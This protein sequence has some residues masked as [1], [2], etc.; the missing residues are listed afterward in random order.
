MFIKTDKIWTRLF[1]HISLI[2]IIF[3]FVI[4]L[5]NGA[6]MERFFVLY[7]ENILAKCA[8][9]I[10]N[11]DITDTETA[12]EKLYDIESDNNVN[13]NIYSDD[14]LVYSTLNQSSFGRPGMN[15]FNLLF[16]KEE[17]MKIL[18][19]KRRDN[20]TVM[21]TESV[22]GTQYIFYRRAA[23]NKQ[24][25]IMI[26][27]S[28]IQQSADVAGGFI[29]IL[30]V[31][32]LAF[33]LIGCIIFSKRFAQ[34]ITEIKDIAV[35]MSKLDFS[36]TLQV[37]G[38]DEISQ[39][40]QSINELSDSLDS[41]LNELKEKNEKLQDEIELERKL[42]VMRKD[43]VANVSHELKTPIAIIQGYA[44]GLRNGGFDKEKS[45]KYCDIIKEESERMN[46]LVL[47]LLELSKLEGGLKLNK[48]RFD[49]LSLIAR[50]ADKN[51]VIMSKKGIVPEIIVPDELYVFADELYIEQALQNYLSNAISHVDEK[52]I[53]RITCEDSGTGVRIGVYNSGSGVSPEDMESIWQ[54]FYRADKSHNRQSGRYGLGLSIVRA[55]ACAHDRPYGIYNTDD[56]VCF[57]IEIEKADK[58]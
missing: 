56:G 25:D 41:A 2:F 57:W 18:S 47:N 13:I 16:R 20:G 50:I 6:L 36:R 3:V 30:S 17:R 27:R 55:I 53:I 24:I 45:D 40:A 11:I 9:T 44:E 37:D 31:A 29:M 23:D 1:L 14:I 32:C 7:E 52:C 42:D 46:H 4:I 10:E 8:D 15:G 54:S 39:L 26:E 51:S 19:E 58:Q 12:A 5:A 21:M 48:T 33:A 34:P 38:N 28:Y 35:N 22:D 43:F 49:L